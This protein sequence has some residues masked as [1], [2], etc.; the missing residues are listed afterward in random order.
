MQMDMSTTA[1]TLFTHTN[2][3]KFSEITKLFF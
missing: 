3:V 1:N 2:F